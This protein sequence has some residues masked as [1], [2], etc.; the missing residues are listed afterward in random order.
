MYICSFD[1]LMFLDIFSVQVGGVSSE[2]WM[3]LRLCRSDRINDKKRKDV[4]IS[5]GRHHI[6]LV[7]N[8]ILSHKYF[9]ARKHSSTVHPR[10]IICRMKQRR[11]N[12]CICCRR[13]G[14]LWWRD[15]VWNRNKWRQIKFD[16]PHNL[17]SVAPIWDWCPPGEAKRWRS[18]KAVWNKE[19]RAVKHTRTRVCARCRLSYSYFIESSFWRLT[20]KGSPPVRTLSSLIHS[21]V[22]QCVSAQVFL[23]IVGIVLGF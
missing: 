20:V 13:T 23:A 15:A 6:L 4:T 21:S 17:P 18:D 19:I 10:G 11:E 2:T 12:S 8:I 5:V 22:S 9:R 16:F 3:R 7:L 14:A 1:T